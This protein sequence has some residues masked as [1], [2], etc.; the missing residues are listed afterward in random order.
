MTEPVEDEDDPSQ[1]QWWLENES[2]REEMDL[3]PYDPPRFADGTYTHEVVFQLED[4]YDCTI[5]FVG[6][7]T[8]YEEAWQIRVDGELVADIG[9]HRDENGNTVFEMT[10]DSFQATVGANQ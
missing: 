10:A 4:Q 6:P 7:N 3:P 9:R 1:P 5:Q 8:R 2:L